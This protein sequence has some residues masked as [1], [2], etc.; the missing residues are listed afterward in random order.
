MLNVTLESRMDHEK[1]ED[2][3][4]NRYKLAS[5]HVNNAE[6]DVRF[7]DIRDLCRKGDVLQKYTILKSDHFPGASS[8]V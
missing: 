4:A 6:V 2:V 5:T 3:V 7:A 1:A 8:V